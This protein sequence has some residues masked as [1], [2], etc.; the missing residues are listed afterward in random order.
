MEALNDITRIVNVLL[1]VAVIVKWLRVAWLV[2]NGKRHG[3]V[4]AAL[5]PAIISFQI[6][7]FALVAQFGKV[8]PYMLN[9]FSQVIRL[10]ALLYFLVL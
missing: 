3:T 7:T 5:F 4:L 6:I 1:A 9:W 10:E 8:D 2:R